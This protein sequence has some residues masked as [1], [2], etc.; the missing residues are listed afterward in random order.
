MVEGQGSED[1]ERELFHQG[2][3]E[4]ESYDSASVSDGADDE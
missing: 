3:N 4:V 1:E 2:L